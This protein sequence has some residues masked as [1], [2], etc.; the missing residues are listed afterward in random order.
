MQEKYLKQIQ[1]LFSEEELNRPI[2]T[3]ELFKNMCVV[4][5]C[6]HIVVLVTL[7][8]LMHTGL[9]DQYVP[10]TFAWIHNQLNQPIR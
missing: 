8:V 10:Q 9:Y 7:L 4:I 3:M 5:F 2:I 6:V 1:G